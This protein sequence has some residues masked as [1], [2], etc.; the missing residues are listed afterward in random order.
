MF[1]C[2]FTLYTR[3]LLLSIFFFAAVFSGDGF[4]NGEGGDRVGGR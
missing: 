3:S 2:D 4:E 1:Q